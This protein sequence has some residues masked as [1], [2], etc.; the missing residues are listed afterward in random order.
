MRRGHDDGPGAG[1]GERVHVDPVRVD[2]DRDG[3]EAAAER[4]LI[5]LHRTGVLER[6]AVDAVRGKDAQHHVQPVPETGA[7]DDSI[8]VDARAANPAQ[9]RGDH[10]PQTQVPGA[11]LVAEIPDRRGAGADAERPRPVAH[12]ERGHVRDAVLEVDRVAPGCGS[13][14]RVAAGRLLGHGYRHRAV[15]H[16]GPRPHP[17]RE[18][19]LGLQLRITVDDHPA[20]PSCSANTRLDGNRS[21]CTSRPSR[22]ASRS[23]CW[24]CALSDSAPPRSTSSSTSG[25]RPLQPTATSRR[26]PPCP[27]PGC[28]R[29]ATCSSTAGRAADRE[30]VSRWSQERV[31]ALDRGTRNDST[32]RDELALALRELSSRRR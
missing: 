3:R 19:P 20:T 21:P 1:R 22:M 11:Q 16:L 24:T 15:R 31:L 10:L 28:R 14:D 18:I 8:S 6:D 9:V 4:D 13:P 27:S 30:R 25:P 23:C 17:G 26:Y 29:Q 12:R 5:V 2:P 7:D 32:R